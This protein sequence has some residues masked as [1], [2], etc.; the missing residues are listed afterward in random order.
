VSIE[1]VGAVAA[2]RAVGGAGGGSAA[3][4]KKCLMGEAEGRR[5]MKEKDVAWA[6]EETS[7]GG[8][9]RSHAISRTLG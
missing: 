7:H 5:P 9:H 2:R 6:E 8:R 1:E 4:R 3:W